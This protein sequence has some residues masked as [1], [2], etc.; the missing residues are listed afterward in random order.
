SSTGVTSRYAS[1]SRLCGGATFRLRSTVGPFGSVMLDG[2]DGQHRSSETTPPNSG[3]ERNLVRPA[4]SCLFLHTREDSRGTV[5]DSSCAS[6][7]VAKMAP[8]PSG[9]ARRA[10]PHR[11][12]AMPDRFGRQPSAWRPPTFL[13]RV[14]PAVTKRLLT[15]GR[16]RQYRKGE[17]L[18]HE[19]GLDS[20][21]VLLLRGLVKVTSAASGRETLLAV[22]V[23]GDILGDGAA[24]TGRPRAASVTAGG[25]VDACLVSGE[26]FRQVMREEPEVVHHLTA[27]VTERLAF[28]N[29]RRLDF[30][31]P[32]RVR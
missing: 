4:V 28:A 2:S 23:P 12:M 18:L 17:R 25:R 30:A 5:F 1:G 20:H 21:V 26:A 9:V 22:R 19:G 16:M 31:Y 10:R 13:G 29:R 14:G 15:S 27:L 11:E 6:R 7:L 3:L 32:V 24:M 8:S